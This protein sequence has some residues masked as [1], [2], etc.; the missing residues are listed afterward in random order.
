[1]AQQNNSMCNYIYIFLALT[2][3][4][5]AAPKTPNVIVFY[6]DD[7]G[8][9]D[10]SLLNS[11]AKFQTPH[12]DRI[13][14]EGIVYTDGHSSDGVCSPS[15][16]SLITGR[17]SWRTYLKKGVM[18][19]DSQPLIANDRTT[20]A[21]LFKRN[22]Y[23]TAMVGKWHMGM[24]FSEDGEKILDGPI[25]KG[26]DYYYGIPAS[27][28]YGYCAWYEMDTTPVAPILYT[29][30]KPN[31][32]A[33]SDYRVMPPYSET[34]EGFNMRVAADFKDIDALKNFT[35]KAKAYISKVHSSDQPFFLYMPLTSPHKPV[36][37]QERFRG[38]SE[39]G[40][41]GDFMIETDYWIGEIIKILEEYDIYKDTMLV[42]SS[43]NGPEKTYSKRMELY[44][45]D[46]AE[47]FLGGKRDIYEGGHR[48]PFL[49]SWPNGIKGGQ[50]YDSPVNQTDLFATFADM[51]GDTLQGNEAEDSHSF[52]SS[53]KGESHPSSPM[54]HHSSAGG[55]A[56]RRDDWKL[57]L[58]TGNQAK[59]NKKNEM[60]LYN[61]KQDPREEK[62]LFKE[63]P[64]LA[65]ELKTLA[66][67][68][69]TSGKTRKEANT[70]NDSPVKVWWN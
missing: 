7:Q 35:E 16:Y 64:E 12:M 8:Y 50:T 36:V 52:A 28:N 44:K 56:I 34:K 31:K 23:Q 60:E 42:L 4:L 66:T 41:Y 57:V 13:G 43:D 65:K 3:C 2:S 46:S 67:E 51:L 40:A 9:G 54:L 37:P 45:H 27:M 38:K 14:Q 17:Y 48:V 69:I 21:G 26:F 11:E 53:F 15:R 20:L 47:Q 22:G 49:I 19:S 30:K 1:M 25:N 33:L 58:G 29:K 61:L 63:K 10:C 59:A 6:T 5:F 18:K 24:T 62:N 32:M 39:A 55:F 70:E 68:I